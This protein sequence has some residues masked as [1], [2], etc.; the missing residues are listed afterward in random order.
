MI[1]VNFF[2]HHTQSKQLIKGFKNVLIKR[3]SGDFVE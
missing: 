3:N 1:I 2:D